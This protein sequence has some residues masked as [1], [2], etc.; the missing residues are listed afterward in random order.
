MAKIINMNKFESFGSVLVVLGIGLLTGYAMYLFV[1][2]PDVPII[3]RLGVVSL[4][5]GILLILLALTK[6]RLME[7]RRKL[8]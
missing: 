6:E 1:Q 3:V 7:K 5:A 8:I 4:V 2:A